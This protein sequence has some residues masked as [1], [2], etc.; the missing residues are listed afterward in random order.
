MKKTKLAFL[1]LFVLAV[2]SLSLS[3]PLRF[4]HAQRN[5]DGGSTERPSYPPTKKVDVVT[6]YFGT[7]V[8]DPYRWLEENDSPEVAAWVEAENKVT[9]AYLDKIPYRAAVKDRLMKLLNYPK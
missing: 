6:D 9:F 3:A 2:L 5:G 1:S 4:V 8:A 7:K